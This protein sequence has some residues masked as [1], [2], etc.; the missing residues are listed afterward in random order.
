MTSLGQCNNE[1]CIGQFISAG[2]VTAGS[3]IVSGSI[4]IASNIAYW[5]E[6]QQNCKVINTEHEITG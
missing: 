3:A 1:G 2:F 5:F 6:K 4:V